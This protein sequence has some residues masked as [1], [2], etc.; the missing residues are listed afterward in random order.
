[1]SKTPITASNITGRGGLIDRVQASL[2]GQHYKVIMSVHWHKSV[3]IQICCQEVLKTPT[4]NLI[5]DRIK[6]RQLF[7]RTHCKKAI[8]YTNK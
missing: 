6:T 8:A 2:G 5:S 1:M 7:L 3:C 4:N